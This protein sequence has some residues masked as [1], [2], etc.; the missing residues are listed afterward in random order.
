VALDVGVVQGEV[1]APEVA[2]VNKNKSI[3]SFKELVVDIL[4]R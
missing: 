1:C 4:E 2:W 3:P